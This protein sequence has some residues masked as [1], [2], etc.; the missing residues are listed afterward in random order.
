MLLQKE[1]FPEEDILVLCTI[2]NIHY[3][4]VFAK[5]DEY[6]KS[7]LIHISEIS[8]GRIR[9]I[10]DYVV[11]GKKVVCKV[12]RVDKNAG[13][14]DLSLRRVND[15][16]KRKKVNEI[17]QEQKAEKIIEQ[18]AKQ[19]KLDP[20]KL[21]KEL[22]GKIFDKYADL[23]SCFKDVVKDTDLLERLGIPK[24]TA[25]Q[26]VDI[27]KVRFKE[28]DVII[29][30]TFHLQSY[31]PNGMEIIKKALIDGESVD[32]KITIRYAGGGSYTVSVTSKNYKD[33]EKILEKS[34]KKV[35]AFTE[36]DLGEGT[37]ERAE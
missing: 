7:G 3:H 6:G 30:G 9:N 36:K 32:D 27:I 22:T 8:P 23:T 10:R 31:R 12:L 26:L 18:I 13:H 34:M 16:Q 5:L 24:K 19:N 35:L 20:I 29:G 11:E 2:T 14:I 25:D 15:N 4:S 21:Y 33:A 28:E 17:K 1:G 37:F